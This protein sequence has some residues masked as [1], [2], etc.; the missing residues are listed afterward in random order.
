M[1]GTRILKVDQVNIKY[2]MIGIS[3]ELP[4]TQK[5]LRVDA[6]ASLAL[7]SLSVILACCDLPYS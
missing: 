5:S 2:L 4:L 1:P 3:F 7:V 6:K